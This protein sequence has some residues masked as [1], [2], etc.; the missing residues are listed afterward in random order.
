MD[1]AWLGEPP[2]A[3]VEESPALLCLELADTEV[4]A[5][6]TAAVAAAV[7][8]GLEEALRV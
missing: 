8:A 6:G 3:P 1:M 4:V 2:W 5:A 7:A